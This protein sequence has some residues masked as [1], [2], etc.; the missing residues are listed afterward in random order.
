[1]AAVPIQTEFKENLAQNLQVKTQSCCH[2]ADMPELHTGP[3]VPAPLGQRLGVKCMAEWP[4]SRKWTPSTARGTKGHDMYGMTKTQ[5]IEEGDQG[6]QCPYPVQGGRGAAPKL[7]AVSLAP[8]C[9]A[10]LGTV[11][12][13]V[14]VE[15]RTCR[16]ARTS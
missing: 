1:M 15:P 11:S 6:D 7:T 16:S 9:R 4:A 8:P 2:S 14:G 12:D 13:P 3:N 5:A 10:G